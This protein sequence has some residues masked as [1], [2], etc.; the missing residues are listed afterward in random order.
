MVLFCCVVGVLIWRR[1]HAILRDVSAIM[2]LYVG[3]RVSLSRWR[4]VYALT[5]VNLH[6]AD[7]SA[8]RMRK[9]SSRPP[10]GDNCSSPSIQIFPMRRPQPFPENFLA[11]SVGLFECNLAVPEVP[12]RQLI[13]DK[14]GALPAPPLLSASQDMNAVLPVH[15]FHVFPARDTPRVDAGFI[16]D[17]VAL[18][19]IVRDTHPLSHC[20]LFAEVEPGF[21]F[22]P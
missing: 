16:D 15:L 17:I 3:A 18:N 22:N 6:I 7:R 1:V 9:N 19:G 11:V 12:L 2:A 10:V 5:V 14:R 4:N 8:G 20:F 21:S 13:E